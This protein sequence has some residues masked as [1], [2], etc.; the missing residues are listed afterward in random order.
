MNYQKDKENFPVFL[1]CMVLILLL[2][3]SVFLLAAVPPVSRDAL[4]HHLAIPKLYL[5]KG[6]IFELPCMDYSYYPMNLDML[7]LIALYLG[8][9]ILAKYIHCFFGLLTAIIIFRFLA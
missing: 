2:V 1:I 9:D 4:V 6:K 7:Y 8:S 5:T 3:L